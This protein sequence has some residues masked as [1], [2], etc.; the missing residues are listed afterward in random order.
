MPAHTSMRWDR[1]P[2]M[3]NDLRGKPRL[4]RRMMTTRNRSVSVLD[5]A[6]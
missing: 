3:F 6:L 1:M 5:M 4:M 2:Q